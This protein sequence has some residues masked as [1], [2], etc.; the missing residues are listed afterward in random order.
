MSTWLQLNQRQEN[1]IPMV[2]CTFIFAL[3]TAVVQ[4]YW[5]S[6]PVPFSCSLTSQSVVPV[7]SALLVWLF[8]W[9]H[10]K[11]DQWNEIHIFQRPEMCFFL[12]WII[13]QI[14]LGAQPNKQ[15]NQHSQKMKPRAARWEQLTST[16]GSQH[17][18]LTVSVADSFFLSFLFQL[19]SSRKFCALSSP[20]S[21][22]SGP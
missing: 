14:C 6:F 13:S 1:P 22:N 15:L 5:K 12:N 16:G 2:F 10:S 3:E 8:L 19:K 11:T 18:H 9:L 7:P 17:G 20:N 21:A 4:G